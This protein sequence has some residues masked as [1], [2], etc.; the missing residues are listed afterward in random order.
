MRALHKTSAKGAKLEV[1]LLTRYISSEVLLCF[2]QEQRDR[3]VQ[4]DE[5]PFE[6]FL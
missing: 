4:S 3:S 6:T 2:E 5:L 1:V